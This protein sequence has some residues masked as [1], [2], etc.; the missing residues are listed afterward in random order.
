MEKRKP[1]SHVYWSSIR[2]FVGRVRREDIQRILVGAD[3]IWKRVRDSGALRKFREDIQDLLALLKD[4]YEGRYPHVPKR[5]IAAVIGGLLYVLMPA[6]MVPDF[7]PAIGLVD[8]AAVITLLM[9]LVRGDLDDYRA[10]R[11]TKSRRA[12]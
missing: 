7:L 4:Y 8:D 9:K 2:K 5:T 6:D 1:Q 12:A 10:G 3:S 11:P